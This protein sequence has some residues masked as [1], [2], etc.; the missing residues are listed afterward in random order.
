MRSGTLA[1]FEQ[2]HFESTEVPLFIKASDLAMIDSATT[3]KD[4]KKNYV[5]VHVHDNEA[6]DDQTW[7]ALAVPYHFAGG[8]TIVAH[9]TIE[10]GAQLEFGENT[11][12]EVRQ[13]GSLTAE[14][15]P[16]KPIVFTGTDPT[17]GYWTGVFFESNSAKNVIRN[18]KIT[19]AGQNGVNFSGGVCIGVRARAA[20]FSSEIAY[21]AVAGIRILQDG[22]LN[23][24]CC[25][26]KP[27]AQ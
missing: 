4:N 10:P 16:E 1:R 11:G 8:S 22:I 18:A 24:E 6:K 20:V 25:N 27:H 15:T 12:I 21:N 3:F 19:Y 7:R 17:P 23:A 14:G 2:N 26:V 5:L 9:V 13:N